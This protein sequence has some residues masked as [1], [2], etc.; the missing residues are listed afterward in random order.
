MVRQG[1]EL[2]SPS[3]Q[4]DGYHIRT[5]MLSSV[6]VAL[7]LAGA[8][9]GFN[10]DRYAA[11]VM[12]LFIA[13][14]GFKISINAIRVLLDASLS[15]ETM[16]KAKE[17]ILDEPL[18][19]RI[20]SL[21]G[22]NSGSYKFIEAEL[23]LK[24]RDLEKAHFI[25]NRIDE[26]LRQ[27]IGNLDRV[28]IHYE[29]VEK[30]THT[31]AV[32]LETQDGR[33]SKEFGEA[34]FF[35]L[36][37]LDSRTGALLSQTILSNDYLEQEKGKGILVA[38]MLVRKGADAVATRKAFHGKGPDYVF[39]DAGVSIDQMDVRHARDAVQLVAE[40]IRESRS[41]GSD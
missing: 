39:S 40:R 23:A 14:A 3:I 17:I 19:D 9:L 33:I 4:A 24:A 15:F 6:V 5:D 34:P 2:G 35:G 8:L 21:R 25:A 37:V 18:V 16:D 32:A 30:S 7:S 12:A 27:N 20:K 26:Q 31:L 13:Y 28:L 22:R 29:P 11:A 38:E 10:I 41:K 1:R 36:Y